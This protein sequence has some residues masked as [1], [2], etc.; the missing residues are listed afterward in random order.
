VYVQ[1]LER[2]DFC[3]VIFILSSF[4]LW[5]ILHGTVIHLCVLVLYSFLEVYRTLICS[6]LVGIVIVMLY[7]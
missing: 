2:P 3:C 4:F 7:Y 5:Y 1:L 6:P